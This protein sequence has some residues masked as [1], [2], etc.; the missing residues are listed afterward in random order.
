MTTDRDDEEADGAPA[1]APE[2]GPDI[3]AVLAALLN[4]TGVLR[5]R[6]RR[7]RKHQ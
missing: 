1:E 7:P 6:K 2:T 5:V 4:A 3:L